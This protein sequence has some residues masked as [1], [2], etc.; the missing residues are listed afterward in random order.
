MIIS[1]ETK[2]GFAFTFLTTGLM[3]QDLLMALALGFVGAAGGYT[4]KVVKDLVLKHKK[5]RVSPIIFEQLYIGLFIFIEMNL[6]T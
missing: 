3:I 5:Q 2:T 4:F 1:P 6:T